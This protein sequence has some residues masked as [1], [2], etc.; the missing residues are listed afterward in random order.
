M[1]N[2][3]INICFKIIFNIII[4]CLL[5]SCKQKEDKNNR[6]VEEKPAI[7]VSEYEFDIKDYEIIMSSQIKGTSQIMYV[8]NLDGLN[9]RKYPDNQSEIIK[10][11]C[12]L[13]VVVIQAENNNILENIEG[14][15]IHI[16]ALMDYRFVIEAGWVL[17]DYLMD[18]EEFNLYINNIINEVKH[19][20]NDEIIQLFYGGWRG[21]DNRD[22]FEFRSDEIYQRMP[23]IAGGSMESGKWYIYNNDLFFDCTTYHEHGGYDT[24]AVGQFYF[25]NENSLILYLLY[26]D[27]VRRF[28]ILNKIE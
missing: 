20:N 3:K 23:Y 11:V 6:I 10:K 16:E 8:N 24:H 2:K 18:K 27:S 25:I 28:F 4:F 13:D 14:K 17:I 12:L 1:L 26:S 5:F 15:W 19:E 22:Y 9:L 7:I 21:Y